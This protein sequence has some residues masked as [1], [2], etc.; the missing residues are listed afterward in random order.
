MKRSI[1]G[2][3][4]LIQGM[5]NAGIDVDS[6]LADIGIKVDALDPSS[7][8]HDRL[9]W[10]I[11]QII[12]KNVEPEKGLFIGQHYALAGYGPLLMLLVTSN[13]IQTA[14]NKG[15][16]YQKLTH[17]FGSLAL[18]ETDERTILN[19]LPVDLKTEIGQVR[20]Q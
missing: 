6:R 19:Y 3:I 15:I 16:K 17:L 5:R 13:D 8:I 4:Y 1:L 10:D 7:T 14:L 9:E 2:L 20:A 12:S 11:Q 18:Y